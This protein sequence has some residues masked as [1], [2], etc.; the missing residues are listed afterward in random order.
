MNRPDKVTTTHERY[1]KT[2]YE[3]EY[4]RGDLFC[5]YCGQPFLYEREGGDY[6]HPDNYYCLDCKEEWSE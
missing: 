6:Y 1:D 4:T 3:E 5:K 2:T